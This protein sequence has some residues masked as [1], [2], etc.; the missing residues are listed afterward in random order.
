MTWNHLGVLDLLQRP[1]AGRDIERGMAHEFLLGEVANLVAV[2]KAHVEQFQSLLLDLP[3]LHDHVAIL[4]P[5][6]LVLLVVLLLFDVEV[7]H[8]QMIDGARHD[9][10][11]QHEM[12]GGDHADGRQESQQD[13]IIRR[14]GRFQRQGLVAALEFRQREQRRHQDA[15]GDQEDRELRQAPDRI[16]GDSADIARMAVE[17]FVAVA[18]Q[19]DDLQQGGE[20]DPQ[21]EKVPQEGPQ[22]IARESH[23]AGRLRPNRV[24]HCARSHFQESSMPPNTM[25]NGSWLRRELAT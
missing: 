12:Q 3:D 6:A 11:G 15:E 25:P 17:H 19:I 13:L 20:T 8:H 4:D 14:T 22:R 2:V 23:H 5:D 7:A 24:S 18:E 21:N 10:I 1:F 16:F 9:L